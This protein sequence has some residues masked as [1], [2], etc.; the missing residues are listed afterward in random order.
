MPLE[1]QL[2]GEVGFLGLNSRDNPATLPKGYVSK[3]VNFRLDR[4]VATTRKGLKKFSE[5]AIYGPDKT[6]VGSGSYLNESGQEIFILLVNDTSVTPNVTR[7]YRFNPETGIFTSP[8]VLP[9]PITSSEGVEI[10][11]AIDKVFISR[12]HEERVLMW[13]M[14]NNPTALVA[15]DEFPKAAGL[16]YYQNRLIAL[17]K[18]KDADDVARK[19]DTVCV[20]HFLQYNKW[21]SS[22]A[23][24][25]NQ[26]GNDEVVAVV[27][28]TMNEFLVL[29]RNSTFYL[30]VG[31]SK[32][33][34]GNSL[35]ADARLE[36]LSVDIGCSAKKTAVQVGPGVMFLSDNGVYMLQHVSSGQPDGVKL[37][38]LSDPISAPIDDVIQRINRD[39]AHKSVAA[40]WNNRYY[41]AVPLDTSTKN[42]A[43]LVFNFILKAW[44]SVDIYDVNQNIFS[45]LVGKRQ[46]QR[47]LFTIDEREGVLLNEELTSDE[48][49]AASGSPILNTTPTTGPYAGLTGAYL[50]D[51][52]VLT[53]F[54]FSSKPVV[55]ELLTRR[56]TAGE[57]KDKRFSSVETDMLLPAGGI[58]ST[59]AVAN[60]PDTETMVDQFVWLSAEDATRKN[61]IRKIAYGL[62][63][64]FITSNLQPTIR[65]NFVK[66]TMNSKNNR[67]SQ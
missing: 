50:D 40:Y 54:G 3:S 14:V 10:V 36:S 47:R 56:F 34:A 21:S 6:I 15:N 45:F 26:G 16:M 46:R 18:H 51:T 62:Q 30:N 39:H 43:V 57:G 38:T 28:W 7:L 42:N 33:V 67:N 27:P 61:P 48:Y 13:N 31:S 64:K 66:F 11:Q 19:R 12:G 52:F 32:Y 22:D 58:V 59:F 35:S 2:D 4:G 24:T 53:E 63:I 44:E 49:G 65:S 60:N 29:C 9:Q 41:L 17:G 20:S 1:Y 25:I 55:G 37:L 23:F 5:P 8:L